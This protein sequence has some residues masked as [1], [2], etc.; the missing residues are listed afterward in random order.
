MQ[1]NQQHQQA[2]QPDFEVQV[3]TLEHATSAGMRGLG[4]L[5]VACACLWNSWDFIVWFAADF[6]NA[7]RILSGPESYSMVLQA[8]LALLGGFAL[9]EGKKKLLFVTLVYAID[10]WFG[11]KSAQISRR[12]PTDRFD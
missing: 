12:T 4:L 10:Q 7:L 8:P 3:V 6:P 2:S 5:V 9:I 11:S 1:G